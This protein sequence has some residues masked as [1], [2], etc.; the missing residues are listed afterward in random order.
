MDSAAFEKY[1][2][3][4]LYSIDLDTA[5]HTI[6][7]MRRYKRQDVLFPLLRDVAVT[8]ARPFSVNRGN[9]I[10]KHQLPSKSHVPKPHRA[11]HD[12]LVRLRMEQFAHTDLQYYRP[13]VAKFSRRTKPWYPMSFKGYDYAGLLGRIAEIEELIV[14]VEC[15][16][17]SE[18]ERCE[19]ALQPFAAGA[20]ALTGRGLSSSVRRRK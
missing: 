5:L 13:R 18:I 1:C 7:V 8:Y 15:S 11:L 9:E 19:A 2:F 17:R 6:R 12:E 10:Q 4:R 16:I 20:T 3:L 14:A